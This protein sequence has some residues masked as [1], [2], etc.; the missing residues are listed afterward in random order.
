MRNLRDIFN[1]EESYAPSMHLDIALECA[2]D[3]N[4][5]SMNYHLTELLFEELSQI[6]NSN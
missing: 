1:L 6:P 5:N 4:K 3:G 2:I